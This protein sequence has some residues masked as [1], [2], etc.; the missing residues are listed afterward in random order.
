MRRWTAWFVTAV[1]V[2]I[3]HYS[4]VIFVTIAALIR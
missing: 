3:D 4:D 1:S 2:P